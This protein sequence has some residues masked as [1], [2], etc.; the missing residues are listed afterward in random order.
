[1][2]PRVISVSTKPGA[3]ALTVMA[4]GPISRANDRVKPSIAALVAPYTAAPGQPANPAIEAMLTIRPPPAPAI[5]ERTTYWVKT[6]G[7]SVLRRIV[8]SISTLFSIAKLPL[9][10]SAA[11]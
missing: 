4:S 7:E 9:V 5:I 11:R 10:P 6:G 1:V 8:R 3:T 2:K